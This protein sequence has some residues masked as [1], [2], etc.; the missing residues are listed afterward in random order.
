MGPQPFPDSRPHARFPL[1]PRSH[2]WGTNEHEGQL[3]AMGCLD[4][5]RQVGVRPS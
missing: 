4:E 3:V 5:P 1:L 2:A